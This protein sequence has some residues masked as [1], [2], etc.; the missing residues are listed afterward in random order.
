M[1]RSGATSVFPFAVTGALLLVWLAVA[2]CKNT[3]V[4]FTSSPSTGI[5]AVGISDAEPNC[6][7]TTVK[8]TVRVQIG[9]SSMPSLTTSPSSAQHIF[10][11]VR[12]IEAH[13][14]TVADDDSADWQ[15]LAPQLARQPVQ[16]DLMARFDPCAAGPL[17]ESVAPAG[18]YS[19]MRLRLVANRPDTGEPVPEVNACGSV[20]FNCIV[21]AD[22]SIQRIAFDG[23][24][25]TLRIATEQIDAGSLLVLPDAGNAI[26]IE[27]RTDLSLALPAGEA[28]RLVPVFTAARR[29]ACQSP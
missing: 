16:V 3:C 7:L 13:L 11:S 25:P 19:Q 10:V 27:F 24:S 18:V 29:A 23:G 14:N 4:S 5:L 8:G 17:G 15:G 1:R 12:G 6:T 22:G 21:R 2:G 26:T 20:G 9:T 28:V